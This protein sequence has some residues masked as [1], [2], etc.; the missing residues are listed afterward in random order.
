MIG[1]LI[2]F[3]RYFFYFNVDYLLIILALYLF[4]L[5]KM[6]MDRK[7]IF[8]ATIIV[9]VVLALMLTPTAIAAGSGG[10][11][12]SGVA[13][14]SGGSSSQIEGT[15]GHAGSS[16]GSS[17]HGGHGAGESQHGGGHSGNKTN[18]GYSGFWPN[19]PAG[20]PSAMNSNGPHHEGW[21]GEP[22]N[23]WI[24]GGSGIFGSG[25]YGLSSIPSYYDAGNYWYMGGWPR[26]F[27]GY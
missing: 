19:G 16:G 2:L 10:S 21:I 4:G 25:G 26:Q 22:M 18:K 13:G 27:L 7:R 5:D 9:V 17:S 15:S 12:S 14:S 8:V 23:P 20:T 24:Y 3:D 6:R 1:Y 11:S